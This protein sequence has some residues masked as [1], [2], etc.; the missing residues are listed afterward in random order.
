[1]PRQR[2]LPTIPTDLQNI[3]LQSVEV[4][5]FKKLRYKPLVIQRDQKWKRLIVGW[6][7]QPIPIREKFFGCLGVG[8]QRRFCDV[9]KPAPHLHPFF[10]VSRKYIIQNTFPRQFIEILGSL[11]RNFLRIFNQQNLA[12]NI[13]VVRKRTLRQKA[14]CT[15]YVRMQQH[16]VLPMGVIGFFQR[17]LIVLRFAHFLI[18]FPAE[19]GI[20]RGQFG[21][22]F[23]QS[24]RINV[25]I[26]VFH[27]ARGK[28]FRPER[29]AVRFGKSCFFTEQNAAFCIAH[30]LLCA[31]AQIQV[32]SIM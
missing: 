14:F 29:A 24:I 30:D 26:V 2:F 18:L 17:I 10:R 23:E 3:E 19:V 12:A 20:G 5:A 9:Q 28:Q 11:M 25:V 27:G 1:M 15:F 32:K 21:V 13:L 4:R 22:Q 31:F 16:L 6:R 7:I 8:F